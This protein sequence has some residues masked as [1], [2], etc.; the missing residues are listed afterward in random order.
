MEK[1]PPAPAKS[2]EEAPEE[3]AL[4]FK[5]AFKRR[6]SSSEYP[7]VDPWKDCANPEEYRPAHEGDLV[8]NQ[9]WVDTA[10]NTKKNLSESDDEDALDSARSQSTRASSTDICATRSLP[11]G[12]TT[13]RHVTRRQSVPGPERTLN[14]RRR[15]QSFAGLPTGN[16]TSTPPRRS[17]R[18]SREGKHA[19]GCPKPGSSCGKEGERTTI[20]SKYESRIHIID[21]E[22][23][24]RQERE[25]KGSLA[26]RQAVRMQARFEKRIE[27]SDDTKPVALWVCVDPLSGSVDLLPRKA[28]SRLEGAHMNHKT[29]VPLAGLG[30]DLENDI[31]FLGSSEKDHPIRKL[32][33]GGQMDV[34][35]IEVKPSAG[36]TSIY[37]VFD[38]VWHIA[39]AAVPGKTEERR[40]LLNG[41]EGVYP[42]SPPLPPVRRERVFFCNNAGAGDWDA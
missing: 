34:R 42:P 30:S 16:S 6:C 25:Y 22:E 36:E 28:A 41:T 20:P 40:I 3:L 31:I 12:C 33:S 32:A 15:S 35:R 5:S 21:F 9:V 23:E 2:E 38:G 19:S 10:K 1:L 29:N 24:E 4:S 27:E 7:I 14:P 26:V 18:R 37:V 13:D 17:S 8:L 11:S 39:D